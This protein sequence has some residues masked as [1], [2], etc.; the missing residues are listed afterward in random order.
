MAEPQVLV[1]REGHLTTITI[2][3]PERL[4]AIDA[5]GA[6]A[7]GKAF[8]AFENDHDQWVA[9]LTGTGRAFCTGNDLIAMSQ[10]S[11]GGGRWRPGS[12]GYGF[13]SICI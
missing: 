12:H 8:E 11:M 10:G 5:E 4:N 1:E 2:N 3:R 7:I 9:I 6:A 13:A